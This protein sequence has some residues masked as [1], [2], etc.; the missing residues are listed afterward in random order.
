MMPTNT[1]MMIITIIVPPSRD[2]LIPPLLAV[3]ALLVAF[4][5]GFPIPV[6]DDEEGSSVDPVGLGMEDMVSVMR[7]FG[8]PSEMLGVGSAPIVTIG[9][10]G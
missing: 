10:G 1:L 4:S 8:L 6:D 5:D 3:F 2:Q 9:M 7:V